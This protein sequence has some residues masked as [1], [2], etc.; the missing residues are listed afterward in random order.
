MEIVMGPTYSLLLTP[1]SFLIRQYPDNKVCCSQVLFFGQ[2]LKNQKS[3]AA[4][5][6]LCILQQGLV[7]LIF[8]TENTARK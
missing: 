7:A 3:N 5:G 2:G 4:R 6:R 1:G 8:K